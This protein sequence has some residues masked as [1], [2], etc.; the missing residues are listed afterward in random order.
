MPATRLAAFFQDLKFTLRQLTKARGFAMVAVLTLALGIGANTAIFS[1][2]HSLLLAPEPYPD[3]NG[4]VRLERMFGG[5]KIPFA[6]GKEMY[7]AWRG[8]AHSLD[9][10]GAAVEETFLVQESG[11][12]DSVGGA[13]ITPGFLR[14]TLRVHPV[15]GR[16]FDSADAL[17]HGAPVA[18][19]G[20]ALW[21]RA[22]GGRTD[23]L[24]RLVHVDGEPY[25]IVGVA[26]PGLVIPMSF[27]PPRDLLLPY[28]VSDTGAM[29]FEAYARL[30]PGI[31]AAAASHEMDVIMHAPPDTGES[32][33]AVARA[34]RAQDY[35]GERQTRTIEVLFAAVGALLLIACANVANLLLARGWGR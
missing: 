29:Y 11:A 7:D 20:S 16:E 23:V 12:S 32:K 21:R 9:S 14:N 13:R 4:I 28:A 33:P 8:G 35:I 31:S 1:V 25:T 17:P 15:I 30:R 6:S 34:M 19:I 10:F 2:V 3:G 22:Y 5:G 27:D 26:P 18:M 24:G